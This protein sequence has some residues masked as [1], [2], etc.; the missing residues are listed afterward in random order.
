MHCPLVRFG[1]WRGTIDKPPLLVRGDANLADA[2]QVCVR[3][4]DVDDYEAHNRHLI[5]SQPLCPS[6]LST[7]W[8]SRSVTAITVG[9]SP[10]WMV[11]GGGRLSLAAKPNSRRDIHHRL[12]ACDAESSA[13]RELFRAW[14]GGRLRVWLPKR[15]LRRSLRRRRQRRSWLIRR[16][17]SLR[18]N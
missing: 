17:Q 10:L 8:E 4:F 6:Q 18:R 5:S 7:D 14:T 15:K 3:S 11:L 1:L 9:C 16:G 12:P 13:W 2:R